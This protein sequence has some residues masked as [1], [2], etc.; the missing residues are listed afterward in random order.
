MAYTPN[1]PPNDPALIPEYLVQELLRVSD[2]IHEAEHHY[3]YYD[4]I[5]TYTNT[6]KILLLK[7]S[8]MI[9]VY[10]LELIC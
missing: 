9:K 3:T 1:Q 10:I 2:A 5:T 4:V 7:S 8:R 6:F